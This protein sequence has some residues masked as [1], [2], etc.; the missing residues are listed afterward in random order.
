MSDETFAQAEDEA[1]EI[2]EAEAYPEEYFARLTDPAPEDDDEPTPASTRPEARA[3]RSLRETLALIDAQPD[4]TT[5]LRG[6]FARLVRP[7]L[8]RVAD[9]FERQERTI[10]EQ[11]VEILRLTRFAERAEARDT[12]NQQELALGRAA[13]DAVGQALVSIAPKLEKLIVETRA[14][15]LTAHDAM[16]PSP[17]FD[18]P[19]LLR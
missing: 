1:A 4:L 13:L 17:P 18:P 14:A 7:D 3:I 19:P 15:C 6:M 5:H 8:D 11:T 9:L 16:P 2:R 12:R 10:E